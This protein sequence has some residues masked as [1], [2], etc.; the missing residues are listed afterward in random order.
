MNAIKPHNGFSLR[1]WGVRGTVPVSSATTLKYGGHTSCVEVRAGGRCF[2]FDAGTGLKPLGDALK[3]RYID[4]LLS[5]THIDHILGIPF[6]APCYDASRHVRFWAGHLRPD[7]ALAE[8][9]GKIM[10][11]PIFPLTTWDFAARV[12]FNDF[13][14]GGELGGDWEQ[15]GI[16]IDTYVLAHPDRATG[17]RISYGGKSVCYVT[18]Y[19]HT[20]GQLEKGLVDFVRGA[21]VLIYDSTYTDE[22]F[23]RYKGWGHSTWQQGVRLADGAGVK[24]LAVFHHDPDATDT[25]LD[26]RAEA[27]NK[28]RPGSVIATEGNVL[29]LIET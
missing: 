17:Y 21:D 12:E 5:H 11:P 7:Y 4:V 13:E 27:L 18:D 16:R 1:F 28:M 25:V 14:A 9:V 29:R 26:K 6:F 10:Q 3:D 19:E 23:E 8:V 15:G 20:Q 22:E 2:V 24:T